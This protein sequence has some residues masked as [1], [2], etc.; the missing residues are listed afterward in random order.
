M[1]AV[2]RTRTRRRP[3][4]RPTPA[5]LL[6]AAV[7][8]LAPLAACSSSDDA[9]AGSAGTATTTTTADGDHG[10]DGPGEAPAADREAAVPGAEWEVAS[11][12]AVGL[13]G[14]VLDDLATKAEAASSNC[15]LVV[16]HGKIA[17]EWYW[18]GTDQHAAQ[19]VWSATKSYTA[20][21]VGIAQAEGDLSIDDSASTWIPEWKGTPAEAVTVKHLLSMDSGRHFDFQTDY[22]KMVGAEDTTAFAIG[23]AQDDPPGEVWTYNNSAVQ[24][25]E[26]VLERSTGEQVPAFAE[27]HLLGPIGMADSHFA[28]DPSG[29]AYTFMG[30]QSTC[31][32]MARFGLLVLHDGAWGDDQVIPADWVEQATE[33]P[34]QDLN[35]TYGYLWWTNLVGTQGTSVSPLRAD[36][37]AAAERT[38]RV[39]GAPEELRWA[40]GLGGQIIQIDTATDTVVVRL[41]PGNPSNTYGPGQTARV[42]TEAVTDGDAPA[43]EPTTT[44]TTEEDGGA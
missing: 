15:L 8:L 10:A 29:N 27:E 32:D 40:L 24:T 14:A 16:R 12:D 23:L 11:P 5:V 34:S 43:A 25:L 21:L 9:S 13:D 20:M 42:V 30:L 37:V 41:G 33:R 44:T 6:A 2:T 18:N 36:E 35:T 4:G 28:T 31:R 22:G 26:Q 19:E 38:Q 39:P 7:L 1:V 17:G 3:G